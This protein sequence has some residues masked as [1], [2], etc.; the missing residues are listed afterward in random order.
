M[1]LL[2]FLAD[3]KGY[4]LGSITPA[5]WA[6]ALLF[7]M[8]GVS[9]SLGRYTNTRDKHSER[10]PLKFNFWFMLTDNAGRIWINLLS[11]LIFLRFSPE[12][13]GTKLTMLSA[14]FVGLSIDK[15]TIWLREKN[16][17]DK[18]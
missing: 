7:A 10:T 12:L 6:A 15:L 13:I 8:V 9:I 16:I 3:F 4:V 17:I 11:V 2:T 18:K 1:N 5:E 14:F